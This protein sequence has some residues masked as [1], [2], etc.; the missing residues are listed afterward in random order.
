[1]IY[2]VIPR[3]QK[4]TV[5][6]ETVFTLTRYCEIEGADKFPKAVNSLK[7]FLTESFSL[8]LLGTGREKIILSLCENIGNEEGY[9]LSVKEDTVII[10]GKTEAGVFYGIQTLKQMLMYGDLSLCS[11]EIEDEP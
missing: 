7:K 1:M 2:P 8:E 5:G 6:D 4:I 3:P 10:K 11:A 9:T